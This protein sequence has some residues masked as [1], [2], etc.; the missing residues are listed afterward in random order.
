ML[1]ACSRRGSAWPSSS[2][3][4]APILGSFHLRPSRTTGHEHTHSGMCARAGASV[5]ACARKCGVVFVR[6]RVHVQVRVESR[7]GA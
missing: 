6:V 3:L 1:A 4:G 7:V 2:T 5:W